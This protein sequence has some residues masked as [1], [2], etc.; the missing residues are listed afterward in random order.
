MSQADI[1][2]VESATASWLELGEFIGASVRRVTE[3]CS[4]S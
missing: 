1:R 3:F 4:R 2:R